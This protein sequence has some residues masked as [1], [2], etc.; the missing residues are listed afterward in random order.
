[1]LIKHRCATLWG[2]TRSDVG[3]RSNPRG[4]AS[5]KIEQIGK[6]LHEVAKGVD[7]QSGAVPQSCEWQVSYKSASLV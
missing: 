3:T 7:C 1:M 2:H 5:T 4:R 6:T